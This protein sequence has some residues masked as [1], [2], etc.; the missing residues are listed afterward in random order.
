MVI[1]VT[2]TSQ[3]VSSTPTT[4]VYGGRRGFYGPGWRGYGWGWGGGQEIRTETLVH[5]E[6]LLYDLAADE[7]VWAG[8]SKTMNPSKA[9]SFVRELINAVGNELQK[10]G[11]V[12][13]QKS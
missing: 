7:L 12:G 13:P 8:Q 4:G 3:E 11:L 5:V 2:G 9:E 6:T 1:Q 10:D